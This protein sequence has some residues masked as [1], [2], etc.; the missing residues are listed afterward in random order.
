M[1]PTNFNST[2]FTWELSTKYSTTCTC[3]SWLNTLNNVKE[4]K[5]CQFPIIHYCAHG[6]RYPEQPTCTSCFK[7]ETGLLYV[8]GCH[9]VWSTITVCFG[10]GIILPR[11]EEYCCVLHILRSTCWSCSRSIRTIISILHSTKIRPLHHTSIMN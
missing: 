7:F 5:I 9:R 10:F 6:N 3:I 11:L 2:L 1:H 4:A 8:A